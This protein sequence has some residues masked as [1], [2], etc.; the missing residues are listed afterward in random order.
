ME[1]TG[2][3]HVVLGDEFTLDL[4]VEAGDAA[5][6]WNGEA[7]IS[8]PSGTPYS[9]VGRSEKY[10]DAA[11]NMKDT[12]IYR[13]EFGV[14]LPDPPECAITDGIGSFKITQF[15]MESFQIQASLKNVPKCCGTY[16]IA[17]EH[18]WARVKATYIGPP[19]GPE[20][21]HDWP[22]Y[23][24][25]DKPRAALPYGSPSL[26][27]SWIVLKKALTGSEL[28][29]KIRDRG[30]WFPYRTA[31]PA[32]NDF[33]N[34]YWD[35]AGWKSLAEFM[36]GLRRVGDPVATRKINGAGLDLTE[37]AIT[38]LGFTFSTTWSGTLYWRKK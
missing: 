26:F 11:G 25:N 10:W 33:Y 18:C 24:D 28:A 13:H 35:D 37:K 2:P 19:I 22:G 4:V 27:N 14:K 12:P 20:S 17:R 9:W 6:P 38:D 29:A 1:V 21:E 31:Y 16:E 23:F 36:Q 8:I 34:D 5:P 3:E 30:P 15:K 7:T 32:G